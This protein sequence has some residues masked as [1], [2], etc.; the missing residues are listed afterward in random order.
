VFVASNRRA[1][2]PS[3]LTDD[4]LLEMALE[5]AVGSKDKLIS[6]TS[7][8]TA[9]GRFASVVSAQIAFRT[10]AWVINNATDTVIAVYVGSNPANKKEVSE[11]EQIIDGISVDTVSP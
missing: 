5:V 7:G 2:S 3:S 11:L 8:N 1:G 10:Q 4:A 9:W 6:Q